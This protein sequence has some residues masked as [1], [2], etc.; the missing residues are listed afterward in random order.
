MS[1]VLSLT[2]ANRTWRGRPISVENDP[3]PT[4]FA[5]HVGFGFH[6]LSELLPLDC[7]VY[8]GSRVFAAYSSDRS[9]DGRAAT[10]KACAQWIT[11]RRL[12]SRHWSS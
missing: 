11:V 4:S 6:L 9:C 10:R 12:K 5:A 8:K 2:G 3:E 7:A 1:A